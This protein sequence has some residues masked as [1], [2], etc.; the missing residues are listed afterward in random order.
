MFVRPDAMIMNAL[1]ERLICSALN[2][3]VECINSAT[4][5]TQT[6]THPDAATTTSTVLLLRL[7][8]VC[9]QK[10]NILRA[11]VVVSTRVCVVERANKNFILRL[12]FCLISL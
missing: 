5:H 8:F 4:S 10:Q 7:L 6:H 9:L 11:S 1:S 3:S 2:F 12:H